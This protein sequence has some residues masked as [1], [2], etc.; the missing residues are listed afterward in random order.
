MFVNLK[1]SYN[2]ET[3]GSRTFYRKYRSGNFNELV[4]QEHII[5]TLSN[6]IEHNRISQ[7]YIFS[8][9]RGTGKT[10]SAR[11]FAKAVNTY[12]QDGQFN[13]LNNDLCQ[14]ISNGSCVDVIEIDAASNTGVDNIRE[15]NEKI[16]FTPVEAFYKIYIIDE[17]HMLSIGAFNALLKT[18]EEPPERVVFILATTEPHKIPITIHSRCQHLQF[19]N[20]TV[21]EI[22]SQLKKIADSE[23]LTVEDEALTLLARN[24]GGCMR[25]GVSL[26]DQ[27]YSFRGENIT[28]K[29]CLYI[30]GATE[31]S[32]LIN[33]LKAVISQNKSAV[34]KQLQSFFDAG[35]NPTQLISDLIVMLKTMLYLKLGCEELLNAGASEELKA[36]VDRCE[37]SFLQSCLE[38]LAQT[39]MECRWFSKPRLLLQIRLMALAEPKV[40][41]SSSAVEP[42]GSSASAAAINVSKPAQVIQSQSRPSV[43]GNVSTASASSHLYSTA[44][45]APPSASSSPSS[46]VS[47]SPFSGAA[48][49]HTSQKPN[50]VSGSTEVNSGNAQAK[51]NQTVTAIQR[52]HNALYAVLKESKVAYEN[53]TLTITLKQSF[54]FFIEKLKEEKTKEIIALAIK[55]HY[56]R[57]LK[58]QVYDPSDSGGSQSSP[59]PNQSMRAVSSEKPITN[60]IA[61]PPV[62]NPVST[63]PKS[64]T[65]RSG[66]NINTIINMFEGSIV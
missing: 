64:T 28:Y 10:S 42:V 51:W 29:E 44:K 57:E 16:N 46:Q 43:S 39:E 52:T 48:T 12:K 22:K 63:T 1:M 32:H 41:A 30:L 20:L 13:E 26:L 23:G 55:D 53:D 5:Q 6:A 54:K 25:D 3:M 37:Q 35:T 27:V 66:E 11:I 2:I 33:V 62:A 19:R 18:L 14:R 7:A 21:E 58:F 45:A 38:S 34:L 61:T 50:L 56:G 47:T 9:P 17:A 4:G 36:L 60:P 65:E 40:I 31:E 59:L 24:A 8:G 15:I 49:S